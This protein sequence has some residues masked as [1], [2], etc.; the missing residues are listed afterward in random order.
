ME[1]DKATI[2][3][4]FNVEIQYTQSH[5]FGLDE[6]LK[7]LD[8]PFGGIFE[9]YHIKRVDVS[10]IVKTPYDYL[11]NHDF[12]SPYRTKARFDKNDKTETVYLGNR[13]NGNVYRMYNKTI[14]LQTDTKDHPINYKK[15]ELFSQ[16]FGDIEDL[17]T[18]EL[19]LHRRYLKPTFGIDTLSDLPK[20]YKAYKEIVGKIRIYKDTDENKQLIKNKNYDR[21]KELLCFVEYEAFERLPSKK[22]KPSERYAIDKAVSTI[23]S[24]ERQMGNLS[25]AQ[26][27]N[28][29]EVLS[30]RLL[31]K[32][33][34]IHIGTS[35]HEEL[36]ENIGAK[37]ANQ[38]NDLEYEAKEVFSP[39][40]LQNPVDLF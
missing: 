27:L 11:T 12:I 14:E 1:Q 9:N 32:D 4:Q 33:I 13:K 3:N 5:M 30:Y 28:I 37:R 31:N 2:A 23:E 7:G 18:F 15:I 10:Q 39:I 24:Y 17:Y 36:Y 22:Y 34:E 40:Y 21:M 25:E 16:Y 6:G 26:K 8:L 35:E 20:L 29:I 19:E 38:T